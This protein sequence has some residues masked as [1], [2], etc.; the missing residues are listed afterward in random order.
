MTERRDGSAYLIEVDHAAWTLGEMLLEPSA[1][2]RPERSIEVCGYQ[3]DELLAAQLGGRE[4]LT[5]SWIVLI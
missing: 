5:S 1:L 2:R 3:L 4:R